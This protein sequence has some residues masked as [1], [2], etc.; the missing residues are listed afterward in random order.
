MPHPLDGLISIH[1]HLLQCP[2][3]IA[4]ELVNDV[5]LEERAVVSLEGG[6]D[7]LVEGLHDR[8]GVGGQVDD[9]DI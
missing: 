7:A 8:G 9:G 1:L 3:G 6:D 2:H 4:V 5:L